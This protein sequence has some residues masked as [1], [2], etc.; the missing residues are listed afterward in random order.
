MIIACVD[1][2]ACRWVYRWA[3]TQIEVL[4]NRHVP[5]AVGSDVPAGLPL[6]SPVPYLPDHPN[7]S[8]N[9]HERWVGLSVARIIRRISNA[10]NR[11][12][13]TGHLSV[14]A[15]IAPTILN[16]LRLPQPVSWVGR[17]LQATNNIDVSFFTEHSF[18][19]L[20]DHR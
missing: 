6:A 3:Q 16:E 7:Y 1:S 12:E 17:P 8:W 19:G 2:R 4:P 11:R 20:I 13:R 14:V 18:H 5:I 15:H 9:R 10:G